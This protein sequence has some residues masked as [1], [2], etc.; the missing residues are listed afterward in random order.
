MNFMLHTVTNYTADGLFL[1][2]FMWG[3]P[4]FVGDTPHENV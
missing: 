2:V 3:V 4:R 1:D